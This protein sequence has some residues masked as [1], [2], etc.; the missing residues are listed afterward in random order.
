[1]AALLLKQPPL[2]GEKAEILII[3]RLELRPSIRATRQRP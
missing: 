3:R 2:T 1:M